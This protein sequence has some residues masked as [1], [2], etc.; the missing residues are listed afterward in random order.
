M[1]CEYIVSHPTKV[2]A[3]DLV[4][5]L[6]EI[7]TPYGL[8]A[9]KRLRGEFPQCRTWGDVHAFL[10]TCS[11]SVLQEKEK[12]LD[13]VFAEVLKDYNVGKMATTYDELL[14]KKMPS[15][16]CTR[17]DTSIIDKTIE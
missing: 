16:S 11:I 3:L 5:S 1:S 12:A 8:D 6:A 7:N 13:D 4:S 10:Q 15:I 17:K 14:K 9:F 2:S